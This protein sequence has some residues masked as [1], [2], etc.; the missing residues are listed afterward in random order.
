MIDFPEL[1]IAQECNRVNVRRLTLKVRILYDFSDNVITM[2]KK[3]MQL[4]Y[5]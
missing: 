1:N 5:M 3:S 4:N 2:G